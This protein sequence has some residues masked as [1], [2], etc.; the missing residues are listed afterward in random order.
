MFPIGF[1]WAASLPREQ[2]QGNHAPDPHIQKFRHLTS[3]EGV[4]EILTAREKPNKLDI[5]K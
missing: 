1:M 3:P 4:K 2:P 5:G